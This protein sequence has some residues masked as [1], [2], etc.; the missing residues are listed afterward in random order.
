VRTAHCRCSSARNFR[1]FVERI[2]AYVTKEYDMTSLR[3]LIPLVLAYLCLT[4]GPAFAHVGVGPVDTFSHG[5]L[6]PLCGIDHILAMVAVGLYAASLGGSALWL[7]P[8]AFVGTMIFGGIL[9]Y[10]GFPLPL[11][12][13]GIGASVIVMGLAVASGMKLPTIAAMALV[14]LFALFHGHAHGSEGAGLGVSFLPYAAGF[15]IATAS[16]HMAGIAFGFGLDC[17]GDRSSKILRR[18]AG[19][20]GALAGVAILTGLLGT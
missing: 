4:V 6:H 7:V 17:F 14:G 10:E 9:G 2:F 19:A 12:E 20:I 3:K 5:F 18:T 1:E 8:T 16:L 11:V 15:I 13:E